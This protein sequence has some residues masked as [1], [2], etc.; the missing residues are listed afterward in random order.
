M[1]LPLLSAISPRR[2]RPSSS[3]D[4]SSS[5][6]AQRTREAV[7]RRVV[8]PRAGTWGR[9]GSGHDHGYESDDDSAWDAGDPASHPRILRPSSS[10]RRGTQADR[11]K[12]ADLIPALRQVVADDTAGDPITGL[13]WTHK[14]TQKLAQELS[15]RGFQVSHTTVARLLRLD[16]YSLRTN[17][18]RLART[19]EPERDRQFRLIER[20]RRWYLSRDLPVLSVDTKKKELVGNFKNPGTC[21]RKDTRDVLDHDFPSDAVGRAIPF[22]IYDQ[23]WNTGFVVV[24]TSH[25]TAEFATEALR[26]WW[27][28]TGFWRYPNARKWLIEADCGGANGNRLWAWKVGLQ[29]LANEFHVAITV[30]HY[31]PGASKWNRI[32]HR[33]FNLISKNWAGEPLV[34]Y[35]TVLNHIRTT[36]SSTG[37]YCQA[38]LDCREYVTKQTVT[39][40]QKSDVLLKPYKILPQ[41]NYTV[42]PNRK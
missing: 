27:L 42:F 24:G 37:F 15:R 35:E 13:R 25:E 31:P 5:R 36:T 7:V 6:L 12:T 21:W 30:S 1:S 20:R 9:G 23:G 38:V 11:K 39:A 34:S 32:E 8:G 41:W 22:G 4:Q 19:H 16:D 40:E 17:R 28:K 2:D 33:M 14:T 29:R 3:G 26:T 10:P 18:K